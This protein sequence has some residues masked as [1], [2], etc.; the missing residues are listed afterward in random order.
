M[1]KWFL[2]T[3]ALGL[4]AAGFRVFEGLC[5]L[6]PIFKWAIFPGLVCSKE[7]GLFGKNL[8]K[9][10]TVTSG[11]TFGLA[12]IFH[13][14]LPSFFSF[15]FGSSFEQGL[16]VARLLLFLSVLG[17]VQEIVS[18]S[19]VALNLEKIYVK[20]L[21]GS[22]LLSVMIEILCFPMAKTSASGL[23]VATRL[24]L[25]LILSYFFLARHARNVA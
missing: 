3:K 22:G 18:L 10:L 2:G 12:F 7:M 13:F 24:T 6:G 1:L 9:A 14:F 21:F 23:A 11:V 20:I 15:S 8:K 4:Y 19:F 16:P 5:L 17:V 25:V